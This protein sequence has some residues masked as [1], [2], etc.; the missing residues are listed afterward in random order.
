M[1]LPQIP[2]DTKRKIATEFKIDIKVFGAAR[3]TETE[4][5]E[6]RIFRLETVAEH[7]CT[8][9][10]VGTIDQPA[11]FCRDPADAVGTVRHKSI[12]S[13]SR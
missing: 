9:E 10:D 1:L 13:G 3:R 11:T 4:T 12:Q 7:I 6:N 8:N 5:Q 2:H